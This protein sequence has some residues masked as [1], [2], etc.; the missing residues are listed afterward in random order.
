MVDDEENIRELLRDILSPGYQVEFASD[1]KQAI[2]IAGGFTPDLLLSD[3]SMPGMNGPA[4]AEIVRSLYPKVKI[5]FMTG[6]HAHVVT[7]EIRSQ[8]KAGVINKPFKLHELLQMV[9]AALKNSESI[10]AIG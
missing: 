4:T 2:T 7:P 5:I 6:F 3:V 10:P 9:E 8:L 1:G